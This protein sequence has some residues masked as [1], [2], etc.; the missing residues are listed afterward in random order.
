M[1]KIDTKLQNWKKVFLSKGGTLT[2]IKAVFS[3]MP[4]YFMPL[5]KMPTWVI[6]KSGNAHEKFSL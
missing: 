4:T 2:F 1:E 3:N 5:F 6:K